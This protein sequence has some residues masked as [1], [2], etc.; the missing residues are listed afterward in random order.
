MI[1]F[2]KIEHNVRAL[3]PKMKEYFSSRT[4]VEFAYLFGS[5]GKGEEGQLSDVDIAVFLSKRIPVEEHFHLRLRMMADVFKVLRTYEVDLIILNHAKLC[6]AYQAV[7]TSQVLFERDSRT[8]I[9]FEAETLDRYFDSKSFR[10]VQQDIYLRQIR[11]GLIF[12]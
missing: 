3:F 4:E 6:L 1:R 12:G 9:E 7:S 5:Y 11:E 10:K 8:R 2:G